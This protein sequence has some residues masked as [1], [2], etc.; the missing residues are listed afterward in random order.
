MVRTALTILLCLPFA[1][2]KTAVAE[3]RRPTSK[4]EVAMAKVTASRPTPAA[5][6]SDPGKAGRVEG[7]THQAGSYWTDRFT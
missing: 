7:S 1:A 4:R 5:K 6:P 2:P 3:T